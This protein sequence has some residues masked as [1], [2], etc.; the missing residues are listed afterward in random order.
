MLFKLKLDIG[1]LIHEKITYEIVDVRPYLAQGDNSSSL[2][3]KNLFA[4]VNHVKMVSSAIH[5][6]LCMPALSKCILIHPFSFGL[7]MVD[8]KP[9][10][11]TLL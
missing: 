11:I 1:L 10:S 5:I 2:L 7:K 3:L 9:N 6:I 4:I 8:T